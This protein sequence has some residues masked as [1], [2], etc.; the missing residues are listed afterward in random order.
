MTR[1]FTFCVRRTYD[2]AVST[3][4]T[5]SRESIGLQGRER[6]LTVVAPSL[7]EE[8]APLVLLFH[9][10]Q[11]NSRVFRKFT[12]GTFDG[13][14]AR[15]GAVLAYVDGFERHFNDSRVG[16][17]FRSRELGIDDVAFT[18]ATIRRLR[19]THDIDPTRVFAVGYSNG[20]QMVLRLIHEAPKLLSGAATIA[21]TQPTP[22]NFLLADGLPTVPKPVRLLAI[23]GTADPLAPYAGGQASLWGKQSRGAVLS[24]PES[25]GYF[26]ERN[27][28][29]T[30]PTEKHPHHGVVV[31]EWS[32]RGKE[33][34]HLWTVHGMGHVVPA[35]HDVV[36]SLGPGT[37]AF[38]AADVIADF[39]GFGTRVCARPATGSE[40]LSPPDSTG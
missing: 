1:A 15:T 38:V 10:S 34:V 8:G 12:A 4:L 5:V 22:E 18:A 23:H 37:R 35:P 16:A 28:I 30:S 36:A 26:A 20:G 19:Q 39:L 21:A 6:T 27:G 3:S 7:V 17:D 40:P 31:S 2:D 24:A 25:A 29:S 11:Q 13:V 14:A 9:G 32:E 33:P